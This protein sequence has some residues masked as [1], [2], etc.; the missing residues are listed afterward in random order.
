MN[1]RLNFR[2]VISTLQFLGHDLIFVSTK[3]AAGHGG[4]AAVG[5]DYVACSNARKLD[6]CSQTRSTRRYVLEEAVLALLR[7]RLMQPEAVS[8]FIAAY[9]VEVNLQRG[10]QSADRARLASERATLGRKL[11]G[12]Y[13]AISEGLR[14]PGLKDRLETMEARRA[15]LDAILAAPVPSP[16][17]LHP[18]LAEIYRRKVADLAATLADPEIGTSALEAIRGLIT[19][20]TVFDGPDG[21]SLQLEGALTAMLDLAQNDKS[22]PGAGLM[23]MPLI[24]RRK[25]LRGQDLRF[26]CRSWPAQSSCCGDQG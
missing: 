4:F 9:T 19:R 2:L 8:A 13:D 3:P 1:S 5:R 22:P 10:T 15:E 21:I 11:E 17:R 6:S 7:D 26:I 18:N 12:L 25:W 14:T 23:S 20:V 16:V 24:V